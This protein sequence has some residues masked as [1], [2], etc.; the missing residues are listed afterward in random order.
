MSEMLVG[1]LS[2][3]VEAE[4]M[5]CFLN[6]GPVLVHC[7]CV[8][9]LMLAVKLASSPPVPSE[10]HMEHSVHVFHIVQPQLFYFK[11]SRHT[12]EHKLSGQ[13]AP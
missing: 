13:D 7:I 2:R 11:G 3:K 6:I 8:K 5:S 4:A 12:E 1:C 10:K 9:L